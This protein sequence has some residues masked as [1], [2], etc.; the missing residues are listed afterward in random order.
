MTR[1]PQ[2][3]C[4][5]TVYAKKHRVNPNCQPA[6]GILC[7]SE[8][9]DDFGDLWKSVEL[10]QLSPNKDVYSNH[11]FFPRACVTLKQTILPR[12]HH[13]GSD[14]AEN[15]TVHEVVLSTKHWETG[16]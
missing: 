5:W 1:S 12:I 4:T 16:L 6:T 14:Y 13:F 10:N 8:D 11:A 3:P 9:L 7:D 2:S 15:V